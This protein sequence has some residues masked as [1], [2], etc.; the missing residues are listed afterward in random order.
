M[1]E[2][3][4]IK[5]PI[6]KYPKQVKA[7]SEQNPVIGLHWKYILDKKSFIHE[8]KLMIDTEE[9]TDFQNGILYSGNYKTAP[10]S[11]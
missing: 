2:R 3:Y 5:Q 6:L 8:F 9:P 4:S 10:K 7:K 1:K 11:F